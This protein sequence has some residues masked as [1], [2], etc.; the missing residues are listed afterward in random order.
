[1]TGMFLNPF[2]EGVILILIGILCMIVGGVWKIDG[3]GP[4]GNTILG[5]GLGYV[6]KTAVEKGIS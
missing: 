2:L 6:G 3:M 4:T 5:I 1:M